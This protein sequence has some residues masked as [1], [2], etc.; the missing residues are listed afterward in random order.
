MLDAV[1]DFA[2]RLTGNNNPTGIRDRDAAVLADNLGR[3]AGAGAPRLLR[4]IEKPLHV[5]R[6]REVRCVRRA[7]GLVCAIPRRLPRYLRPRLW[8]LLP[9]DLLGCRRG[10]AERRSAVKLHQKVGRGGKPA[11]G[12][13]NAAQRRGDAGAQLRRE[14]AG[15]RQLRQ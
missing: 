15:H 14:A 1:L 3:D 6:A 13:R 4:Q 9:V 7:R 2:G 10:R 11:G 5:G 12:G 8:R